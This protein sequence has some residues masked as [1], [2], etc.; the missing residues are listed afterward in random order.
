MGR[1]DDAVSEVVTSGQVLGSIVLF[2]VIYILLGALWIYVLNRKIQHGPEPPGET[3]TGRD[4]LLGAAGALAGRDE[5]LTGKG[6][7]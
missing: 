3:E 1:E 2:S 6:E 7:A 4:G 5:S